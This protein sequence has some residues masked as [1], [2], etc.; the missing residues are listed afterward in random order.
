MSK[1][2]KCGIDDL[3]GLFDDLVS[4]ADVLS[5]KLMA[6]ISSAITAERLRLGM[7]QSEFADHIHAT[8]SQI[9]RWEHGDYNFSLNKIAEI[10][11]RLNMD[12]NFSMA[13][14]AKENSAKTDSH[15]ETVSCK[16]INFRPKIAS[17]D[18]QM[19]TE[20][21]EIDELEEM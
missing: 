21:V 10:A 18:F 2:V 17:H 6:Q 15:D 11:S 5:A 1:N 20:T 8:Q 7:N 3:L 4:S 16:I 12:V 9:S 14:I 19:I 13:P